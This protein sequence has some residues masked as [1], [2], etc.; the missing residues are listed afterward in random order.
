MQ[1]KLQAEVVAAALENNGTVRHC[2]KTKAGRR[3]G[4]SD[5]SICPSNERMNE[6]LNVQPNV[7]PTNLHTN[8]LIPSYQPSNQPAY[9]FIDPPTHLPTNHAYQ[10]TNNQ[11]TNISTCL[12]ASKPTY[13]QPTKQS[14]NARTNK[15]T[16][17]STSQ[18]TNQP[19]SS[20]LTK[21]SVN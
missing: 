15:R 3:G 4:M 2:L 10:L 8:V 14:P 18:L 19:I 13:V 6:H 17:Q 20:Q 21:Q 9:Y 11:P 7:Q 1:E 16:S 5:L 12:P